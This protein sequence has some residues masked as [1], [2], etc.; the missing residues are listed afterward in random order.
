LLQTV[1]Q[2]N[3][4]CVVAEFSKNGDRT[5]QSRGRDG[6]IRAFSAGEGAES[7]SSHGFASPG[8]VAGGSDQIEIDTAYDNYF[9]LHDC[10]PHL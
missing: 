2:L 4:E 6:L 9:F 3:A 7:G 10:R 5:S 8:N 1:S